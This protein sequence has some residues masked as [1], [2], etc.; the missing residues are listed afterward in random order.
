M[1]IAPTGNQGAA[2]PSRHASDGVPAQVK[3]DGNPDDS[4]A[5]LLIQ[6][7]EGHGGD[8]GECDAFEQAQGQNDGKIPGQ[9]GQQGDEGGGNQGEGHQLFPFDGVSFKS[10]DEKARGHADG[11]KGDGKAA[12]GRGNGKIP[13]EVGKDWLEKVQLG[14]DRQSGKE[15]AVPDPS[16]ADRFPSGFGMVHSQVLHAVHGLSMLPKEWLPFSTCFR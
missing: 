3:A 10:P 14:E 9:G 7:G 4:R 2:N 11:G 13:A 6:I 1:P 16:E 12:H 15:D 8:S 5:Y